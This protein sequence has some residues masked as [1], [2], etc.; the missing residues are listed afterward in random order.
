LS[1]ILLTPSAIF[2]MTPHNQSW[3]PTEN[4]KEESNDA[5]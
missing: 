5:R 3:M 2:R 4:L 1:T